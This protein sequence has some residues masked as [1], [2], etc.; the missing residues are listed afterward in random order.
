MKRNIKNKLSNEIVQAIYSNDFLLITEW[1]N[2]DT[3]NFID[4][5]NRSIIFHAVLADS[6]D[7]VSLL[8]ESSPDLNI[9]DSRAWYPLHYAAQSYSPKVLDLLIRHGAMLEVKDDY[10]NTPLWRAVFTSNGRG[11]VIKSL[12]SNG[13]NPHNANN[14]DIT[15]YKLAYTI[16]NYD[17][18]QFFENTK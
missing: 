18:R 2:R 14:S 17:V 15:P 6:I 5:D 12:L 16:A 9:K 7:F 1:M 8:L 4:S 10:G 11:N 3:I 13:A